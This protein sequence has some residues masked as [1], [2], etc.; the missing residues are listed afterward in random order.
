MG[1]KRTGEEKRRGREESG[2]RDGET[3]HRMD[4]G[5]KS[6]DRQGA[7]IQSDNTEG[8]VH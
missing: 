4:H 1:I 6:Q 8:E 3:A 2:R 7:E 5:R